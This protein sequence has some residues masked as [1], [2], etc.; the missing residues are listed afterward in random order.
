MGIAQRPEASRGGEDVGVGSPL[1]AELDQVH[2]APQCSGQKLIRLGVA[3]QVKT[4][5][6]QLFVS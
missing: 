3:D 4:R 2:A 6:F 5:L 1:H